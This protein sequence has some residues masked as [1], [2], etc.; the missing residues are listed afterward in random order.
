M[1]LPVFARK[2]VPPAPPEDAALRFIVITEDEPFYTRLRG[3]ADG[4]QWRIGRA[5]SIDEI[6]KQIGRPPTPIVIYER[7]LAGG[8]WRAGLMKLHQTTI[9]P[10]VL[11]ASRVADEYLWQ[12]VVRN[13]GYDILPKT[14]PDE[15]LIR[16]LKFAWFWARSGVHPNAG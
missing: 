15:K 14:A 8:D 12:E 13:H 9:K 5:Q 4:C 1:R 10:C 3:I 11:L 6:Q 16:L 2:P 7:D